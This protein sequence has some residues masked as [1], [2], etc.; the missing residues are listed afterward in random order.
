MD[1]IKPWLPVI[2]LGTLGLGSF[3]AAAGVLGEIHEA[4]GEDLLP[5][6]A[7][8]TEWVRANTSGALVPLLVLLTRVLAAE[9]WYVHLG[10]VLLGVILLWARERRFEAAGLLVSLGLAVVGVVVAKLVFQRPRPDV[11]WALAFERSFSFPSGHAAH[12]V[13]LYGMAA[14]LASRLTRRYRAGAVA[15]F[16][17]VVLIAGTGWSRVY[18]GVHYPT[19]VAAGFAVGGIW[20]LAGILTTELLYVLARPRL[21]EE[22][23]TAAVCLGSHSIRAADALARRAAAIRRV[24]SRRS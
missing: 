17:A 6:D 24:R 12:A 16:S 11:P 2:L 10:A 21:P 1:R 18:L 15:V 23:R 22:L 3:W 5:V 19:D 20:L 8:L 4:A 9:L 13:V 14:Y 7:A